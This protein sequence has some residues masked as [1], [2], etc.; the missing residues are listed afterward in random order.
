MIGRFDLP[1]EQAD[2]QAPAQEAMHQCLSSGSVHAQRAVS[3][4][5]QTYS[6]DHPTGS[7]HQHHVTTIA[8]PKPLNAI[9]H[10][11]TGVA[12]HEANFRTLDITRLNEVCLTSSLD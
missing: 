1:T 11:T 2:I 9:N 3:Y 4:A 8:N 7:Q 12:R 10:R 6:Q 5:K